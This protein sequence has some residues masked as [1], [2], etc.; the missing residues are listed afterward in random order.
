MHRT[1]R[2]G[3]ASNGRRSAIAAVV[4][5][6]ATVPMAF[7]TNSNCPTS[8][9]PA[10]LATVNTDANGMSSGGAT[11]ST[12]GCGATD[13]TFGNFFVSGFS[14]TGGDTTFT[15]ATDS[16]ATANAVANLYTVS[17]GVSLA[18]AGFDTTATETGNF[19]LLTQ[20][21]TLTGV[22]PVTNDSVDR[23]ELTLTGVDLPGQQFGGNT[24]SIEVTILACVGTTTAPAATFTACTTGT[25]ETI[26]LTASNATGTAIT[27]ATEN[28]ILT[29]PTA[30]SVI[31][32]D[33]TIKLTSNNNGAAS[34]TGFDED[35]ES[36]EP[37]TFVLLGTALAAVGLLRF[38]ARRRAAAGAIQ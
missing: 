18:A 28:F 2:R 15:T 22:K 38:R 23:I 4:F 35:F 31:S 13:E 27:G 36:P 25:A 33:D 34:F 20:F 26:T 37:S 12:T 9:T 11:V 14:A 8:G 6:L 21:G 10:T 5:A 29:L 16:F 32:V 3:H 24:S 17:G 7:G 30:T 1:F 19:A